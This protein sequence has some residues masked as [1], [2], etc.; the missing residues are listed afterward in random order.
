MSSRI[1]WMKAGCVPTV[2]AR[3]RLMQFRSN[4]FCFGIQVKQDLHVV[5][6]K[7]NGHNHYVYDPLRLNL[8]EI[9]ANIGFQPGDMR[10]STAALVD[11]LVVARSDALRYKPAGFFQLSD[12]TLRAPST[13]NWCSEDHAHRAVTLVKL[14]KRL[15]CLLD[16]GQRKDGCKTHYQMCT[17]TNCIQRGSHLR[18]TDGSQNRN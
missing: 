5:R 6:D 14:R 11:Q 4:L 8:F 1:I 17:P 16:T 15:L 9:V 12:V 13:W 7:S 18:G 10:G 2:S 3:T